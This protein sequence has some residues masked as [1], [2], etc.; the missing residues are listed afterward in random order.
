[1]KFGELMLVLLIVVI[2]SGSAKLPSLGERLR[3]QQTRRGTRAASPPDDW[4][5][6]AAIALLLSFA[7]AV[8]AV[9]SG[10]R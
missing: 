6:I 10:H 8:A 3:V 5:F 2:A 1:M 7:L 9:I 4:L